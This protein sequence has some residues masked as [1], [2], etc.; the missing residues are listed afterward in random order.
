MYMY[1]I[2]GIFTFGREVIHCVTEEP[3]MKSLQ[4]TILAFM[5]KDCLQQNMITCQLDS[6]CLKATDSSQM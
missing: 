4:A 2:A 6:Q 1:K 5:W 3:H